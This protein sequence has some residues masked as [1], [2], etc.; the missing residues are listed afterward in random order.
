MA[1]PFSDKLTHHETKATALDQHILKS[2]INGFFEI[3]CAITG[4]FCKKIERHDLFIDY[5]SVF[6]EIAQLGRNGFYLL[7]E[8][9]IKS[10]F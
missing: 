10:E 6:R 4:N 5:V 3:S 2:K 8:K 7:N 9:F 1:I